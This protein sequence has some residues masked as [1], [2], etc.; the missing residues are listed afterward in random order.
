MVFDTHKIHCILG[1][2]GTLCTFGKLNKT[3]NFDI[4]EVIIQTQKYD[5]FS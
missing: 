2:K 5:S 1:V 4:N 3:Q